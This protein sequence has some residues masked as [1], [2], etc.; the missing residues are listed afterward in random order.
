MFF[1]NSGRAERTCQIPWFYREI[2]VEIGGWIEV[3]DWI[4]VWNPIFVAKY[5]LWMEVDRDILKP[6]QHYRRLPDHFYAFPTC[7]ENILTTLRQVSDPIGSLWQL[8]F[9]SK[10]EKKPQISYNLLENKLSQLSPHKWPLLPGECRSSHGWFVGA[11][12]RL[13]RPLVLGHDSRAT[14]AWAPVQPK[15]VVFG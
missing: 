5:P 6:M 14:R 12:P 11:P 7:F 3:Q 15:N 13:R 10:S 2:G 8:D 9:Q 1:T 4:P